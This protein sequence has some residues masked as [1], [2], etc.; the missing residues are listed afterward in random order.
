MTL[1]C[2][3]SQN[4]NQP[5]H[6]CVNDISK[7]KPLLSVCGKVHSYEWSLEWLLFYNRNF[8]ERILALELKERLF[9]S[10]EGRWRPSQAF[11][12]KFPAI[13]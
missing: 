2:D 13:F 7:N 8:T 9:M 6:F 1:N 10:I 5:D 3:L 11:S 12:E 4:L